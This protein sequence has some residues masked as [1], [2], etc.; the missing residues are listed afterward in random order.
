MSLNDD[1]KIVPFGRPNGRKALPPL[2]FPDITPTGIIRPTCANARI[3]IG[4]LGI[5]CEYDEFHD[6]LLI[7]GHEVDKYAG[8]LSDHA[9]LY[10]RSLIDQKFEF[11]PGRANMRDACIQ[12]CL[13]NRFDPIVDYI[14]GL[15]WD[16]VERLEEWLSTYLG[17]EDTPLNRAIGRIALIALVRRAG[18]PAAASSAAFGTQTYAVQLSFPGS[19]SSTGG[20]RIAIVSPNDNAVSSTAGTLLPANWTDVFRCSPGQRVSAISNDAGT[21]SLSITELTD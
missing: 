12:L 10:L 5:T 1:S 18:N 7:G 14:N 3:A 15:D 11:D 9:L 13:E 17:A 16:G 20:C 8:E 19:V 6:I 21:F 2:E 4:L